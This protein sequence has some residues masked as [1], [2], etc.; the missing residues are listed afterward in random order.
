MGWPRIAG[1]RAMLNIDFLPCLNQP[2]G[3]YAFP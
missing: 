2:E 1:N 3:A